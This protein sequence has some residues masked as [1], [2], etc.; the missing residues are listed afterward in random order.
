MHV[1]FLQQ[2]CIIEYRGYIWFPI[3]NRDGIIIHLQLAVYFSMCI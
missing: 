3:L 1:F 2:Y